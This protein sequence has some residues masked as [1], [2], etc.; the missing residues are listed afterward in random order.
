VKKHV[1]ISFTLKKCFDYL[2]SITSRKYF[3]FY[4]PLLKY[5]ELDLHYRNRVGKIIRIFLDPWKEL[6]M[7]EGLVGFFSLAQTKIV[8]YF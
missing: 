8:D 2:E 6:L 4:P 7:P 3:Y 5:R 1:E